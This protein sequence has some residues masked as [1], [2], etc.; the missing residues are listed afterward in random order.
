MRA[1]ASERAPQGQVRQRLELVVIDP[2]EHRCS[3]LDRLARRMRRVGARVQQVAQVQM[4]VRVRTKMLVEV[5]EDGSGGRVHR[6]HAGLLG[7]LT[8]YR[9]LGSLAMLDVSAG[10]EPDAQSAMLVEQ[11]PTAREIDDEG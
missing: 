11:E 3:V 6:L 4:H 5:D 2:A 9:I 1:Q 10:L 7:G 8:Q